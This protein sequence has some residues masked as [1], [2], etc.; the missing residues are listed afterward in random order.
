M[1]V[2]LSYSTKDSLFLAAEEVY[3]KLNQKADFFIITLHP[4]YGYEDVNSVLTKFFRNNYLAFHAVDS[5]ADEEIVEGLVVLSLKFERNGKIN[6]FSLRELK[7][8][9]LNEI[10]SYLNRNKDDL[11]II[12]G[13]FN[14]QKFGFFIEELSQYLNY[15]PI[16]NIAGGISSGFEVDEELLTYIFSENLVIKKGLAI[17]SFKN[18]NFSIGT[19]LG[20]KP[21]GITYEITKAEGYSIYSVDSGI[22]FPYIVEGLLSNLPSKEIK[23]LWY[24]PLLILDEEEGYQ[25]TLRTFRELKK[26]KVNMF[27]PVR[28][29]EKFKFT[30]ATSK[31]LLNESKKVAKELRSSLNFP[32]LVF[33]FSCIAR[34]YVLED[35]QEE[36]LKVYTSTLNSH[37]FGFFTFGEVGPDKKK[38]KLKFFNQTSMVI[39][40]EER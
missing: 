39:A 9:S 2:E 18:F 30:F 34:Q 6:L 1:K 4:K 25:S 7:E 37:L 31:E 17:L 23:Q 3:K 21:Y 19:V 14:D 11:H 27:G 8:N 10:S 32:E 36:E 13:N 16:N 40:L 20:F 28:N 24:S 33:N 29:G 26:D 5:F 38:R 22:P 15:K 35:K 12:I